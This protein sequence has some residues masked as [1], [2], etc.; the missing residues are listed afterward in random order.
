MD[1]NVQNTWKE[2]R[3]G[4]YNIQWKDDCHVLEEHEGMAYSWKA[5]EGSF[6]IEPGLGICA[7]DDNMYVEKS[8][9]VWSRG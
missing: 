2:R 9:K 5:M 8:G 1:L 6:W 3:E 4:E 7:C